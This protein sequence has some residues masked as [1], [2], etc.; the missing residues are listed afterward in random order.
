MAG[1]N[2]WVL[3]GGRGEDHL[4]KTNANTDSYWRFH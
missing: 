2:V 3:Q 4:L 1:L